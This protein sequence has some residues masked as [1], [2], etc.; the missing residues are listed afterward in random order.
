MTSVFH[1]DP[2]HVETGAAGLDFG[3][4]DI[5]FDGVEQGGGSFEARVFLNNPNVDENTERSPDNGYAGSLHVYGYGEW[6]GP[7]A[8]PGQARAPMSRYIMA[9]EAVRKALRQGPDVHVTT[10]VVP[11][12]ASLS[13]DQ[14]TIDPARVSI[15]IDP[16]PETS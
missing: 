14:L 1:S 15:R 12:R 9:T 10:V 8:S 7:E 11:T 5:V 2:I 3:R 6:P 16:E 13:G 4:A